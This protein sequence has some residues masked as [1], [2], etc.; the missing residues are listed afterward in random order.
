MSHIEGAE[1]MNLI[2]LVEQ[3]KKTCRSSACNV[4]LILLRITAE[5]AGLTFT[6]KEK[7]VFM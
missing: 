2:A 6:D 3:H 1:K 7:E 4:S 5:K